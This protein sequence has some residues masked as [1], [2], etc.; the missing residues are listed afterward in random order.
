MDKARRKYGVIGRLSGKYFGENIDLSNSDKVKFFNLFIK[1]A[2]IKDALPIQEES[3]LDAIKAEGMFEVPNITNALIQPS[4]QWMVDNDFFKEDLYEVYINNIKLSD[5]QKAGSETYGYIEGDVVGII[6]Y[7]DLPIGNAEAKIVTEDDELFKRKRGEKPRSTYDGVDVGFTFDGCL[8]AFFEILGFLFGLFALLALLMLIIKLPLL[9]LILLLGFIISS[10]DYVIKFLAPLLGLFLGLMLL[11]SLAALLFIDG[12]D[13]QKRDYTW[14]DS[15]KDKTIFQRDTVYPSDSTFQVEEYIIQHREWQDVFNK[16]YIADLML[17]VSDY[18]NSS[19]NKQHL[20]LSNWGDLYADISEYDKPGL[21]YIIDEFECIR[22]EENLNEL[23]FAN[24]VVSCI[25]DIPYVYVLEN[26]S[27]YAKTN[28]LSTPG[29][30]ENQK[31]GINTPLEFIAKLK[32]DCDT[33]TVMLFSLLKHFGYKVAIANSDIYR[34]SMLMISMPGLTGDY[35]EYKGDN[36]FFWETT[37]SD[38]K[39]GVLPPENRNTNY[40][41]IVLN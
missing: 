12:N 32:G 21:I 38:W 14:E 29:C 23:A 27:C 10:L 19:A 37:Y 7:E 28:G 36:Y 15:D 5:V 31:F 13:R 1:E 25:Q 18:E 2:V 22:G 6:S 39:L 34:H 3:Y 41:K 20:W 16:D 40:W 9:L 4:K 8:D 35:L 30:E 17:K 26:E 33:R 24:M 11:A